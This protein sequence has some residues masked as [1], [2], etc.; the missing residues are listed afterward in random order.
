MQLTRLL[1]F[2]STRRIRI[3]VTT[4]SDFIVREVNNLILANELQSKEFY[5]NEGEWLNRENV[6]CSETILDE[7]CREFMLEQKTVYR[8]GAAIERI[9]NAITEQASVTA[10]LY[11]DLQEIDRNA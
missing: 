4:H 5:S 2:L 1:A 9:D 3:L 7:Q 6:S 11:D 10:R 8:H